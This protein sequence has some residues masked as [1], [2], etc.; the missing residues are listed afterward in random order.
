M[1]KAIANII[2]QLF[3]CQKRLCIQKMGAVI[4]FLIDFYT[5]S[6]PRIFS[7]NQKPLVMF[8]VQWILLVSLIVGGVIY[9]RNDETKKKAS[10]GLFRLDKDNPPQ[11]GWQYKILCKNLPKTV[12][13]YP[14]S[15]AEAPTI[16]PADYLLTKLDGRLVW[17]PKMSWFPVLEFSSVL[18]VSEGIK[19]GEQ[20]EYR[21]SPDG[22]TYRFESKDRT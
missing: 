15:R 8:A 2:V 21:V 5:S 16:M 18:W 7:S 17:V 9:S 13:G 3:K 22:K 14:D 12:Y 19:C 20:F 10:K 6:Y 1:F 4:T 11:V